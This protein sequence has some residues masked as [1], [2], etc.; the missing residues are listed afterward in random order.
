MGPWGAV[1]GGSAGGGEEP[2][3]SYLEAGGEGGGDG[4]AEQGPRDAALPGHLSTSF[5]LG[6]RQKGE[7]QQLP[8]PERGGRRGA[9]RRGPCRRLEG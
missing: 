4:A 3:A 2:P 6:S 9:G 7:P 8:L 5:S 1:R